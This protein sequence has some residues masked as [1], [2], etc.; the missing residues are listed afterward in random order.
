MKALILNTSYIPPMGKEY[1]ASAYPA[2]GIYVQGNHLLIR[3]TPPTAAG[4][5]YVTG[6]MGGASLLSETDVGHRI[7]TGGEPREVRGVSE[8]F[9]LKAMAIAQNPELAT[10]L[11]K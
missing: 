6:F 8:D 9:V 3:F 10:R 11:I 1:D 4:A 2:D 5:P 7:D